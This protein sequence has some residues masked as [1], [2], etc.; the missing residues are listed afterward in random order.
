MPSATPTDPSQLPLFV[1]GTLRRGQ[2]N[3]HL[4]AGRYLHLLPA[5]LH[6]F[7]RTEPLMI[8]ARP[9]GIVHGEIYFLRSE[10]YQQT[11][12]ACDDLEGI[13]PGATIGPYYRRLQVSVESA[14]GT[15]TAWAYANP[16][17]PDRP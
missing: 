6:D 1:F 14:E 10:S 2:C 3:H 16:S 8:A 11:L 17:T 15:H 7:A 4:L 9:G 12:R 5:R 13:P